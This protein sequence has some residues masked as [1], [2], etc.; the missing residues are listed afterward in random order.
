MDPDGDGGICH[1]FLTEAISRF[2]E[3]DTVEGAL[4]GAVEDLSRQLS[5]MTMNDDYK[6]YIGVRFPVKAHEFH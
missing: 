1:D 3:D 4:V 5:K 2:P 6:P